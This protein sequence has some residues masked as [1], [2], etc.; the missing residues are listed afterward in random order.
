MEMDARGEDGARLRVSRRSGRSGKGEGKGREGKRREGKRR[1][2]EEGNQKQTRNGED[3]SDVVTF[4]GRRDDFQKLTYFEVFIGSIV[5][6]HFFLFQIH[7]LK[8]SAG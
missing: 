6:R 8:G 2:E 7:K 3:Y 1:E 4:G 5:A